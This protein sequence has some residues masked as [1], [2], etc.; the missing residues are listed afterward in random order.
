MLWERCFGVPQSWGGVSLPPWQGTEG[1]DFA[2]DVVHAFVRLSARPLFPPSLP[3]SIVLLIVPSIAQVNV[4]MDPVLLVKKY[5][6]KIKELKQ[7][8]AM[9]DALADRWAGVPSISCC[10]R[11][12][13][14][15]PAHVQMFCCASVRLFLTALDC[16]CCLVSSQVWSCVRRVHARATGGPEAGGVLVPDGGPR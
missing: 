7:E 2:C 14:M 8:L 12:L 1:L 10:A 16:G 5:E 9:H 11:A 4:E 13:L 15:C 3:P 6:K